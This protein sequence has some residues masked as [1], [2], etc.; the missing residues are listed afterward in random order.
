LQVQDDPRLHD[1]NLDFWIDI[2]EGLAHWQADHYRSDHILWAMGSDFNY[3][4][5][6]HWYKNLDKLIHHV[7]ARGNI[8]LLYSTPTIYTEAK[9]Q[10]NLTWE[11]RFDD[12]MPL[13]DA[14]HH[15][16]SGA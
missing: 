13:A 6:D 16:W 15:Y 14:P 9:N 1:Y 11:A 12:V 3:E 5:A 7:N 10:A 4:N 8:N 2:L